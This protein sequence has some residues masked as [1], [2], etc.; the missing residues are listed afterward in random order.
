MTKKILAR[1]DEKIGRRAARRKFVFWSSVMQERQ[2]WQS[3]GRLLQAERERRGWSLAEIER[4]RGPNAATVV[5]HEQ[6]AIRTLLALRKHTQVFDW[7]VPDVLWRILSPADAQPR[8]TPELLAIF[9]KYQ[10]LPAASQQ[11][12][13]DLIRVIPPSPPSAPSA[14]PVAR[15]TRRQTPPRAARVRE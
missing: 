9:E 3:V 15:K 1:Q 6:G 14:P 12:L 10:Q 4:R 2:L 11:A 5:A 8:L 7:H 13:S